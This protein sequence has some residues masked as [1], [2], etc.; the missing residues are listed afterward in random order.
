M[1][2]LTSLL[3]DRQ[4]GAGGAIV[5]IGMLIVSAI[6]VWL[7]N[8]A[9]AIYAEKIAPKTASKIAKVNA[10][11]RQRREDSILR[12]AEK[13]NA[14]AEKINTRRAHRAQNNEWNTLAATCAAGRKI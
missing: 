8:T 4:G 7:W 5:F 3:D 14:Q 11:R 1:E 6:L 13:L 2:F 10:I 12:K 9:R